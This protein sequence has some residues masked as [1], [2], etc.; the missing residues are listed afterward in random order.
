MICS[1][2]SSCANFVSLMGPPND[3]NFLLGMIEKR[4]IR[5]LSVP[6]C[7]WGLEAQRLLATEQYSN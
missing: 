2:K 7:V 4:Q 5:T 6:F 3:Y 1:V